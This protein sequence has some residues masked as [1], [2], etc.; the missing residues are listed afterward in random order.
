MVVAPLITAVTVSQQSSLIFIP[1]SSLKC[2]STVQA[3]SQVHLYSAV[4]V[5]VQRE[6][7]AQPVC[8]ENAMQGICDPPCGQ[9][10]TI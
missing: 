1:G 10:W 2:I 6:E 9:M 3:T 4:Q 5:Q 8:S 7:S